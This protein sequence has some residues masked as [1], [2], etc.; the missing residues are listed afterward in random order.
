MKANGLPITTRKFTDMSLLGDELDD[1]QDIE[2]QGDWHTAAIVGLTEWANG[3]YAIEVAH[4]TEQGTAGGTIVQTVIYCPTTGKFVG[5]PGFF[6]GSSFRY[7]V[8]ECPIPEPVSLVLLSMGG[9]ALLGR[10]AKR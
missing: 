6:D 10:R 3:C 2:L 4:D 1:D 8:V 9:F 7:A 5:S